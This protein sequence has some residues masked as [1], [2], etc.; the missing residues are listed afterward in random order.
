MVVPEP[1]TWALMVAGV[2]GLVFWQRR[3]NSR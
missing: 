3:R 2:A 1:K